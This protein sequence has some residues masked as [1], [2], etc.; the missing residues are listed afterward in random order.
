MVECWVYYMY[1]VEYW[2]GKKKKKVETK[3]QNDDVPFAD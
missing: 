1:A 3:S 2:G